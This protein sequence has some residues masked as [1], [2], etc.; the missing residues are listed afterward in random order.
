[1]NHS[2]LQVRGVIA[3]EDG[4]TL[5]GGPHHRKGKG[6]RKGRKGRKA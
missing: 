5:R 3:N 6:R 2:L 4:T 1:M